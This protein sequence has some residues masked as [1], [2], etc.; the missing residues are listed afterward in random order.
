MTG[1]PLHVVC[2]HGP[3]AVAFCGEDVTD[4]PWD[5][6]GDPCDACEDRL[7]DLEGR[8]FD[9]CPETGGICTCDLPDEAL[10]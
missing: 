3:G 8:G 2:G 7:V 10:S 9:V 4:A 1:D 6:Q 5:D